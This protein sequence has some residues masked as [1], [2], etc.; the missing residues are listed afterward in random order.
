MQALLSNLTLDGMTRVNR[1]VTLPRG[2]AGIAET[3]RLMAVN[4][5]ASQQV[6]SL[7]HLA[8]TITANVRSKDWRAEAA[9]VQNW[10][11][12]NIRYT[13]DP[14]ALELI[15]SP[16]I[17]LERKQGDCDDHSQL[18]AVLLSCLGHEVRFVAVGP[19]PGRYGHVYAETLINGTWT[20]VE[21]TEPWALGQQPPAAKQVSRMVF[22]IATAQGDELN[23]LGF[24]GSVF[25][26][27]KSHITK[28]L[29]I[30][31]NPLKELKRDAQL[32]PAAA[33]GFA[34]GGIYGAIAGAAIADVTRTAKEEAAKKLNAQADAE[35]QKVIGEN[36][37]EIANAVG[38]PGQAAAI[39][40]RLR[41]A[42]DPQAEA[43]AI[44]AEFQ[45]KIAAQ[46]AQQRVQPL[47]LA[48]GSLAPKGAV[49]TALES[50]KTDSTPLLLAGAGVLGLL[51]FAL[52]LR[53]AK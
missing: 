53:G 50:I 19:A 11:R 38:E 45:K 24:F 3:L 46:Q 28:P 34:S 35:Y 48:P 7:I 52:V 47:V 44:I 29:R 51:G 5:L 9:A 8:S 37:R 2:E 33:S 39:G 10:V 6:P 42:K 14:A 36:A 32:L 13:R 16:R 43:T 22:A 26:T 20:P 12:Q 49:V 1:V 17:T 30:V 27:I 18:V 21:T 23:Q 31:K 25:K 4:V 40:A 41:A 15:Q